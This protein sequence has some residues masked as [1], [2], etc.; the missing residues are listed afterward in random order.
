MLNA[1][2][3]LIIV[4][5]LPASFMLS[6]SAIFLNFLNPSISFFG[7]FTTAKMLAGLSVVEIFSIT[8][9]FVR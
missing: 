7:F 9:S 4:P 1:D 2:A 5:R 8:F 6:R 3:L